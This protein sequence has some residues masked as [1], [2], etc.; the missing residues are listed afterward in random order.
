ML[1]RVAPLGLLFPK[2]NRNIM[3]ISK[4]QAHAR[5]KGIKDRITEIEKE[6]RL[7]IIDKVKKSNLQ[8]ELERLKKRV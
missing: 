4:K 2:Y 7:P 6:L 1:H 3:P 5:A 8:Y